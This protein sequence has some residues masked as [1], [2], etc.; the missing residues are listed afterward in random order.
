MFAKFRYFDLTPAWATFY[1]T[2]EDSPEEEGATVELF[3][4]VSG[5]GRVR[6]ATVVLRK[7]SRQ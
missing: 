6:G 2:P 7:T 5:R 4:G 1:A 3:V